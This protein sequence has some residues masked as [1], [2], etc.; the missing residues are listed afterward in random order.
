MT[1][2]GNN[3]PDRH[4]QRPAAGGVQL[5]PARLHVRG[6]ERGDRGVRLLQPN[7]QRRVRD[8]VQGI[9][10]GRCPAGA[11]GAARRRQADTVAGRQLRRGNGGTYLLLDVSPQFH[12]DQMYSISISRLP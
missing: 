3:L 12:I 4:E 2:G 8:G 7:R 10:R 9:H 6:A 11:P 1:W 5:Q